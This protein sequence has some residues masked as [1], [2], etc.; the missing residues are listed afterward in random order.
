MSADTFSFI[1]ILIYAGKPLLWESCWTHAVEAWDKLF[2][3]SIQC[4]VVLVWKHTTSSQH[5]LILPKPWLLMYSHPNDVIFELL[6][7]CDKL[8]SFANGARICIGK[9]SRASGNVVQQGRTS[10]EQQILEAMTA[11]SSLQWITCLSVLCSQKPE[12]TIASES[13]ADIMVRLS[14]RHVHVCCSNF[15]LPHK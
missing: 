6:S 8:Q 9:Q 14:F 15:V 5:I 11:L 3:Q 12:T 10:V 1:W 7:F 4:E 2:W 13:C